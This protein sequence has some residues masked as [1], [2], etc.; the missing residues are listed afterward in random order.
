MDVYIVIDKN[1]IPK[2]SHNLHDVIDLWGIDE[3]TLLKIVE[4]LPDM[5]D[6]YEAIPDTYGVAGKW[7][8]VERIT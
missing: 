5:F 1:G 2:W 8:A 4:T 3:G 6:V 7:V